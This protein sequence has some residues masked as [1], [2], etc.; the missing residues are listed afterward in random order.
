MDKLKNLIFTLLICALSLNSC[1]K[2]NKKSQNHNHNNSF[3]VEVETYKIEPINKKQFIKSTGEL[4]SP[5]TTIITSEVKGKVAFIDIPEGKEV[6]TGHIL[7]KIEDSSTLADI[8]IAEAKLERAK[9]Y[10]ERMKT[11]K[12]EGAISEQTLNDALKELKETEGSIDSANSAQDKTVLKAPFNGTLSLRQISLGSFIDAGDEVVRISKTYPLDLLFSLPE[13]YVSKIKPN[14]Q[15]QFTLA[16]MEEEKYIAKV[17]AIDPYIDPATR[18][19]KIKAQ[20][21]NKSK[22][23]LPGRFANIELE[24]G[25]TKDAIYIPQEAIV[26]EKDSNFVFIVSP[27]NTTIKKEISIGEQSEGSVQILM[28]LLKDD[29]IITSGHQKLQEG[30]KVSIMQSSAIHNDFLDHISDDNI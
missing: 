5:E 21:I 24:I 11:L 9:D 6:G 1:S 3:P 4:K 10:Y 13:E 29:I 15:V 28:G 23:L 26:P 7:A 20:V 25:E 12:E 27:E 30:S 14:G 17:T 22:E 8:K 16:N 19:I 18:N 2:A